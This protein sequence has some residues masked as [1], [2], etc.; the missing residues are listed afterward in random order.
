MRTTGSVSAVRRNGAINYSGENR[1]TARA[2][3]RNEGREMIN[4]KTMGQRLAG[5]S[6]DILAML[7]LAR[8]RCFELDRPDVELRSPDLCESP[9]QLMAKFLEYEELRIINCIGN[10]PDR[11]TRNGRVL[12]PT[13]CALGWLQAASIGDDITPE[14]PLLQPAQ[15]GR[16]RFGGNFKNV[17][18]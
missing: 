4:R 10:Q 1:K 13:Y 9:H 12:Y 3:S 17:F 2:N 5:M 14:L 18:R 15:G 7:F 16:I 8:T 6:I 11:E